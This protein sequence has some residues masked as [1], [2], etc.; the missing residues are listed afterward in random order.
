MVWVAVTF[1]SVAF[2]PV[3]LE[4]KVMVMVIVALALNILQR[5]MSPLRRFSEGFNT[6]YAAMAAYYLPSVLALYTANSVWTSSYHNLYYVMWCVFL[7]MFTSHGLGEMKTYTLNAGVDQRWR[8]L[9]LIL[10]L[11]WLQWGLIWSSDRT[12]IVAAITVYFFLRHYDLAVYLA[13]D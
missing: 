13:A 8:L 7:L 2:L 6:Q 5:F 11:A 4:I 3:S 10:Y 12:L 1:S 9:Q